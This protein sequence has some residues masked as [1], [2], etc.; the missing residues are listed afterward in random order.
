LDGPGGS[1]ASIVQNTTAPRRTVEEVL[2][3]LGDDIEKTRDIYRLRSDRVNEY[4]QN[5]GFDQLARTALGDP[6]SG[7]LQHSSDLLRTIDDLVRAAPASNPSL[8]HVSATA[9]TVARRALWLDSS[10]DLNGSNILFVGD[11]DLTSL[12]VALL[13]PGAEITV[14]DI[15]DRILGFIGSNARRLGLKIRCL[16]SDFRL[17][18]PRAAAETADL[19]VTDPPYTPEGIKLFLARGVQGLR[20]TESARLIMAYGYSP[21]R[22]ALGLF[23]Q[24]AV[25]S[26]GLVVEGI[27]PKFNRYDGA[28]AIGSAADLYICQPTAKSRQAARAAVAV[29]TQN[30]YTH[31]RQSVETTADVLGEAAEAVLTEVGEPVILVGSDWPKSA[32]GSHPHTTLS[33]LLSSGVPTV[34]Q[35]RQ[36]LRVVANLLDDDGSRLLRLLL[37]ANASRVV[38]VVSNHHPDIRNGGAQQELQSLTAPKYR[39]RFRRSWPSPLY[40]VVEAHR[41]DPADLEGR[42]RPAAWLQSRAHGKVGN[43]WRDALINAYPSAGMT[44]NRARGIIRDGATDPNLLDVPLIELARCD[45]ASVL[46]DVRG[47]AESVLR[48]GADR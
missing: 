34:Q 40:A 3:A 5:F 46:E 36:G 32:S 9:E 43:T 39:L 8:D 42:D 16:Y 11:H 25:S 12:A 37:A 14:V 22:P 27:I 47:S 26:L 15:D 2:D 10:Y 13:C 7:R 35:R 20:N 44:K 23:V 31:G 29:D 45:I 33:T 4:R 21:R 1:L 38:S 30:I 6:L 41:N 48:A 17:G 28:E 24:R 19:V 18:L